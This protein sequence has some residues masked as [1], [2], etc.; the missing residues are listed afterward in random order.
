MWKFPRNKLPLF[1]GV[2]SLKQDS[3]ESKVTNGILAFAAYRSG[4]KLYAI[5][6][7]A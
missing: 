3:R 5:V 7:I 6:T 2:K 4:Y 1:P